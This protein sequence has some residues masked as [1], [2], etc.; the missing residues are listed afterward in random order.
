MRRLLWALWLRRVFNDKGYF[1]SALDGGMKVRD[2]FGIKLITKVLTP[3]PIKGKE[4]MTED[5]VVTEDVYDL[6]KEGANFVWLVGTRYSELSLRFSYENPSICYGI[7]DSFDYNEHDIK[8]PKN[9]LGVRFKAQEGSFLAGY[10]AAKMS[11]RNKIG[12]LSGPRL[13]ILKIFSW[14]SSRS[15]LC[16]P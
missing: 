14:I 10:V 4:L 13:S 1:Q 6:Q 2:E 15:F 8:V 3:Y 5:E 7:I 16:K 12:F 11:R 9:S